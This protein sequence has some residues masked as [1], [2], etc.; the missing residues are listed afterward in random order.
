MFSINFGD[1]IND[2]L[3]FSF[4]IAKQIFLVLHIFDF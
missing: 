1:F 2:P 4:N 3:S